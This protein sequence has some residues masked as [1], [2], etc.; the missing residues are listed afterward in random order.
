MTHHAKKQDHDSRGRTV[1]GWMVC[2]SYLCENP[3]DLSIVRR[4]PS[5]SAVSWDAIF[6]GAGCGGV[7][8]T[9]DADVRESILARE[10]FVGSGEPMSADYHWD[11]GR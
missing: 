2:S 11:R 7:G 9:G 3:H 1:C 4:L 8:S 6:G 10:G 5:M